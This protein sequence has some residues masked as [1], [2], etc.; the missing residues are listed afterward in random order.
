[1]KLPLSWL[2]EHV[3]LTDSVEGIAETLVR[4]GHEV[5][6]IETPRASVRGVKVGQILSKEKHPDAD[7]LSL[8]KVDVGE[9]EPLGIVCGATNMGAWDKV[10]V[11]TVGTSLPNGLTIKKGKIRGQES[12]G[13][14]CS[15]A[16]LGIA[17]DAAGLLILP[18]DAPVGAEVGEVLGLEEAVIEVSIT[19]N[20][21]DC[22]SLLGLARDLAAVYDLELVQPDCSGVTADESVAAPTVKLENADDCPLYLARRIDGVAVTDSPVWMQSRLIQAGMR[23]V[24]GI[25]DV[26]NYIMLDM[27]QPMHAFD[28]AAL[29][30]GIT[31]RSAHAGEPFAALDGRK[32]DLAQGDLAITDDEGV[33]ALAGIMGS[34]PSG[35]STATTSIVL[36]SAYFRPA[37][38]SLSRR[39]YGMVSEASMRYERGVDP[40]QVARAMQ[41]ASRLIAELFGGKAGDVT[42]AGSDAALLASRSFSFPASRIDRRLGIEIDVANDAVLERMGFGLKR[43]GNKL[44]VAVP[45]HRHDVALAEDISEEYAR[46][47][48][49]DAI[50][51][52]LPPL[53]IA[54]QVEKSPALD[55]AVQGGCNQIISYAFIS[56]AEQRLFTPDDGRDVVLANPISEAMAVMRRSIWPGM[57]AVARHNLNR[58]QDGLRLV[59]HGRTYEA[60]AGDG[61]EL[62]SERDWLGWLLAGQVQDD[63]WYAPARTADFFDLKGMVEAW[64]AHM[65]LT[66][67]FIADD[68][69]QGLLAGQSARIVVGRGEVGRIGRVSKDVCEAYDIEVPVFVAEIALDGLPAARAPKFAPLPEFP[70]SSRDLVFLF[71][72]HVRAEDIV[73]AAVKAG[74]KLVTEARIFDRYEGKGVP[75][76]KV[77]LG[78]RFALQASD[79]TLTQQDSDTASQAIVDEMSKRFGAVLRG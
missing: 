15:E 47:V 29:S 33:I 27:G 5:E 50:P 14:C 36:E 60:T 55:L 40:A 52:E 77:S 42:V 41:R 16:E 31:V 13:M 11:A 20:R 71:D 24:N 61:A 43:D 25:V 45:S 53:T 51:E 78:V 2:T 44:T 65:G 46:V 67:R 63:Q 6:G 7:K 56:A 79:R 75:E 72:R 34:E 49:F 62:A 12:R 18:A 39:S 68:G 21:G 23:P 58:Q 57:L 32:L 70:G 19:P 73:Q 4:L 66:A 38:I 26:L 8:L 28:A 1:M 9:A 64:L 74:G 3:H 35:V 37:R 22:M 54:A 17:E 69:M 10:P 48:G 30:G 59:E 76:D